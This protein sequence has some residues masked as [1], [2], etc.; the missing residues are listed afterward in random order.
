MKRDAMDENIVGYLLKALEADE[1]DQ[2]DAYV[3]AHP[4]EC[5][6]LERLRVALAPLAADTD[7]A[8][9]PPGLAVRTL[10]RVAEHHC[11][12]LPPAPPAP[13]SILDMPARRGWRWVDALIAAGILFCAL[14]LVPPLANRLWQHYQVYS[15][16]NNLR[17]F[18]NGLMEY[19]ES[20]GGSLP[21]VEA[22]GARSVAG[23]FVPILH[24]AGVLDK[25]VSLSCSPLAKRPP[26]DRSV[27]ELEELYAERQEEFRDICRGLSGCYAYTL[28]YFDG[29]ELH[30]MRRNDDGRS[31]ILAD[32]PPSGPPLFAD[33]NS[34]NHGGRG[35]NVLFLDGS[36]SFCTNR[37]VGLG[38]D[39]IYLNR[40]HR[41][42][43]GIGPHDTVL[44]SSSTSP[45]PRDEE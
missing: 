11:R 22:Q 36:V 31:P 15:C 23:I 41:Q 42:A 33:A 1:Q 17:K 20:H 32:C 10:A 28:G 12:K 3:R 8:E 2:V 29:K 14:T 45:W 37:G 19:S 43:A 16:A 7:D 24:D 4:D 40:E 30:G 27:R 25:D 13:P 9:P 18:H 21:K 6:R 39:D 5:H 38:G 34:S 44:G 26:S 35:Q